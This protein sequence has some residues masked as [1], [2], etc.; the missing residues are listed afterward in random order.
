MIDQPVQVIF[1]PAAGRGRGSQE[2]PRIMAALQQAG[3]H[4]ALAETKGSGHAI[5]L[6][7]QARA[8]GCTTVVAVGGDGT[9]SEVINGLALATPA[10]AVVGRLG[11][12]PMG[13]GNDFAEMAGCPREPAA[14]A[15][16][17]VAGV[18]R[19]IDLGHATITSGRGNVGRYF[20]NNVGV[21]FEAAATLESYRINWLRGPLLYGLAALRSCPTPV[22][23]TTWET[24]TGEQGHRSQPT[25]LI[26][27]GNSRRTGGGFF[28]TPHAELDDGQLDVGLTAALSSLRVLWL[29]PKALRGK[30]IGD[31]AVTMVRC[32]RLTISPAAPVPVHVDGEV[33]SATASQIE[34]KLEPGR[35]ALIVSPAHPATNRSGQ[36]SGALL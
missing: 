3:L 16:A 20:G 6:A 34:I 5:A 18:T 2:K 30:H 36:S 21:G 32:R 28:L 23:E 10:G 35:L 27:V 8:A 22:V 13:S 15:A 11:I 12:I 14:V 24:A 1:N 29:L 9:V 19:P 7:R 25:L 17:L 4:F 26:S 33:I 31:P